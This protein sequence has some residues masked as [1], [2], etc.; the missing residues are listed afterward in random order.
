[1]S[2]HEFM[3]TTPPKPKKKKLFNDDPKKIVP[4]LE[5]CHNCKVKNEL[6]HLAKQYGLTGY[7]S[8]KK[9]EIRDMIYEAI[10]EG[11]EKEVTEYEKKGYNEVVYRCTCKYKIKTRIPSRRKSSTRPCP[12]CGKLMK[13]KQV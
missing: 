4:F 8:K 6:M 13:P 11:K 7:S 10:R 5:E 2:L 1:M 9:E 3:G 12:K